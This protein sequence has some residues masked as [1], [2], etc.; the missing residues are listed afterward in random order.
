M[1]SGRLHDHVE[2]PGSY[3]A[4]AF[5][6]YQDMAVFNIAHLTTQIHRNV[7]LLKCAEFKS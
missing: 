6:L 3:A 7:L 4:L 1:A 2:N 5:S